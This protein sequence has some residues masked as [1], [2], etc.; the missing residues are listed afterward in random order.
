MSA[1][2]VIW[3]IEKILQLKKENKNISTEK[4]ERLA[5][6]FEEIAKCIE[7]MLADFYQGKIPR[8]E[9]NK[10]EVLVDELP[11]VLSS[12]YNPNSNTEDKDKIQTL[13]KNLSQVIETDIIQI[14]KKLDIDI[15][16]QNISDFDLLNNN[17]LQRNRH[18][19]KQLQK[20]EEI[21]AMQ[22]FSGKFKGLS[23]AIRARSIDLDLYQY[24]IEK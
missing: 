10:L 1:K 13:K 11:N 7:L 17:R 5:Q 8:V 22:R 2:L 23:I 18:I 20:S 24:L 3:I 4:W 12:V 9:G 15:A 16:S 14:A 21:K 6:Y 19:L